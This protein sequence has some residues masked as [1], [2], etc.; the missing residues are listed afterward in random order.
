M[1]QYVES[2][3]LFSLLAKPFQGQKKSEQRT[4]PSTRLISTWKCLPLKAVGVK[5]WK[6]FSLSC[7]SVWEN[8]RAFTLC[9]DSPSLCGE[10]SPFLIPFHYCQRWWTTKENSDIFAD[11]PLRACIVFLLFILHVN[12][13]TFTTGKPSKTFG[14]SNW[15]WPL[16]SFA[17]VF[18][19]FCARSFVCAYNFHIES[20]IPG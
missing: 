5:S 20:Q 8:L 12:D 9:V 15:V 16:H 17:E 14:S 4:N 11:C 13:L 7:P 18:Y 2:S 3:F 1:R 19:L 10:A 6:S